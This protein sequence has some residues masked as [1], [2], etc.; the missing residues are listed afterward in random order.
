MTFPPHFQ[1]NLEWH[2]ER[3]AKVAHRR[4]I[5]RSSTRRRLQESHRGRQ[6]LSRPREHPDWRR[7]GVSKAWTI[8]TL[9]LFVIIFLFTLFA[10]VLAYWTDC[11]NLK[12]PMAKVEGDA[13]SYIWL[14]A[15]A[16]LIFSLLMSALSNIS[17]ACGLDRVA[18]WNLKCNTYAFRLRWYFDC[19]RIIE[20]ILRPRTYSEENVKHGKGPTLKN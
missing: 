8:G 14:L 17:N 3:L 16:S 18:K 9:A 7:S 1:L 10:N 11:N 5:R 13:C 4:H 15:I 19:N 2:R 6:A 12:R 20:T